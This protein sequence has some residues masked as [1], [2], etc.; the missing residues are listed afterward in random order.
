MNRFEK[1]KLKRNI[2][3]H[4]NA[5]MY[6]A[7]FIMASII[8]IAAAAN[9][10][11]KIAY[12]DGTQMVSTAKASVA[13]ENSDNPKVA[14]IETNIEAEMTAEEITTTTQETTEVQ[15]EA[16]V[17]LKIKITADSLNIRKEASTDSEAIGSAMMN[18]EF[19]VIAQNGDWIE[20]KLDGKSGFIKAEFAEIIE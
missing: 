12:V 17:V 2:Y 18:Q 4:G 16:S 7:I 20:I 5:I 8:T 10:T 9:R 3:K 11:D 6:T 19:E 1:R 14:S 13:I 15:T